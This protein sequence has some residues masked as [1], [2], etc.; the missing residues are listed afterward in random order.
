MATL[1][2][3]NATLDQA[4]GPNQLEQ[5]LKDA[6]VK[7]CLDTY[8]IGG[9]TETSGSTLD[10]CPALPSKARVLAIGIRVSAAQTSLTIN[11][12]DDAD[13]DRYAAAS[14]AL[15][16]A[17]FHWFSGQNY[18]TGT[19]DGDTQLKIT[20]GGATMTAGTLQVFVL[21]TMD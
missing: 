14:T 12:G 6:R 17:G 20:T 8:T 21:Y 19:T 7:A 16:T 3:T 13:D 2:A 18:Q 9:S 5:G 11:L 1:V 4:G 15:Q 10:I